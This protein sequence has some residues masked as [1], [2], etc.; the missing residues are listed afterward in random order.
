MYICTYDAND[1]EDHYDTRAALGAPGSDATGNPLKDPGTG[2]PVNAD[3][4]EGDNSGWGAQEPCLDGDLGESCFVCL[5]GRREDILLECGHGGL[6]V[7]CAMSLWA[8]YV[9]G[10][11]CS[12]MRTLDMY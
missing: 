8:R 3:A 7:S 4:P 11:V 6:C 5:D 10:H 2:N 1:E 9:R 12:S